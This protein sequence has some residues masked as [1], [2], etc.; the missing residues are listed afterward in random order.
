VQ[1]GSTPENGQ[2]AAGSSPDK[3]VF[4]GNP[5]IESALSNMPPKEAAEMCF[6]ALGKMS[7]ADREVAM[8]QFLSCLGGMP[9]V[10]SDSGVDPEIDDQYEDDGNDFDPD[11]QTFP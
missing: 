10:D 8:E 3:N 1:L 5:D 6:A 2:P 4:E 7:E 9:E 11:P